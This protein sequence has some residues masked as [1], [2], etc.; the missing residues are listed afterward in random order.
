MALILVNSLAVIANLKRE[1][2]SME[3]CLGG[4]MKKEMKLLIANLDSAVEGIN[5]I[6]TYLYGPK[7]E[8]NLIESFQSSNNLK[9]EICPIEPGQNLKGPLEGGTSLECL[10]N[11]DNSCADGIGAIESFNDKNDSGDGVSA[12]ESYHHLLCTKIPSIASTWEMPWVI[13]K[14]GDH[15]VSFVLSD[16]PR[17]KMELNAK[18]IAKSRVSL[19]LMPETDG[20]VVHLKKKV[21]D[22]V[23]EY[24]E[25][26]SNELLDFTL[27]LFRRRSHLI[28]RDLRKAIKMETPEEVMFVKAKNNQKLARARK[29]LRSGLFRKERLTPAPASVERIKFE[30]HGSDQDSPESDP[31]PYERDPE[32]NPVGDPEYDPYHD[33]TPDPNDDSDPYGSESGSD[34]V[35]NPGS[36]DIPPTG[37]ESKS[38]GNGA[39]TATMKNGKS[40]SKKSRRKRGSK[41]RKGNFEYVKERLHPPLH[42]RV[43]Q[44]K[45][46]STAAKH[47]EHMKEVHNAS[48]PECCLC[49]KKFSSVE[50]LAT[51]IKISHWNFHGYKLIPCRHCGQRLSERHCQEHNRVDHDRMEDCPFCAFSTANSLDNES[52]DNLVR[53]AVPSITPKQ[54]LANHIHHEHFEKT[55]KP[56][57]CNFCQTT[58][59]TLE[60]LREHQN[61]E[62]RPEERRVPLCR[63]VRPKGSKEPRVIC[64]ICGKSLA[65]SYL[66]THVKAVHSEN[67]G[68]RNQCQFCE[69]SYLYPKLLRVHLLSVHF[70]EK[71]DKKCTVCSKAF[72]GL[73]KLRNHMK[74][75]A[76]KTK[77]CPHC[78]KV[79]STYSNLLQHS[80]SHEPP[81]YKCRSCNREFV[82][83][84]GLKTHL[85]QVHK[86]DD[87]ESYV[88]NISL[89]P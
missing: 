60:L 65:E 13:D 69:K 66:S 49:P 25:V 22:K 37:T 51:H 55:F 67:K 68:K 80:K 29:K 75:H 10:D 27:E 39:E 47:V 64:T 14:K 87:W 63:K 33:P 76:P 86:F 2:E 24:Y 23:A 38:M 34:S 17:Q 52:I 41:R 43:C 46:G 6:Q 31:E 58:V 28:E 88:E 5:L 26:P 50:D 19:W 36:S 15:S 48:D 45:I 35:D 84:C 1:L 11:L 74:I 71:S 59:R 16:S 21:I 61:M 82:Y 9:E 8:V 32:Y 20:E 72:A 78:D 54:N 56:L 18:L 73:E 89:K 53:Y 77:A 79:F 4:A 7:V 40:D 44:A 3:E 85:T 30:P 62:L 81:R 70:P 12:I 83:R 57:R 42:C